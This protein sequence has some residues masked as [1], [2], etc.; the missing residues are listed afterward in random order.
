MLWRSSTL[1][2]SD[3]KLSILVVDD[4]PGILETMADILVEKDFTVTMAS[5]GF[6]AIELVKEKHFDA[7]I[8]DVRM[9]GIDGVET[10]K[11]MKKIKR[12][13]KTIFMTAYALEDM[14]KEAKAEGAMAVLIKPIDI[15]ALDSM[16][17]SNSDSGHTIGAGTFC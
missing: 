1:C 10:F 8:M 12:V 14:I 13:P 16:L 15:E 17:K 6:K 5:D 2:G 9:P 3:A 11:K 4:D 7:I